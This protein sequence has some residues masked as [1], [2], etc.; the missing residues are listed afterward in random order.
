[1]IKINLL[2]HK[3]VKP[4]EKGEMLLQFGVIALTVAVVLGL[5]GWYYLLS[6]K[7][8]DLTRID[9]EKTAQ[10]EKLKKKTSEVENYKQTKLDSENK[11]KT[12]EEIDKGRVRMTQVLNDINRVMSK[13]LWL[14]SL[15]VA[16]GTFKLDGAGL[17]KAKITAFAD[18]LKN[19]ATF[20]GVSLGDLTDTPSGVSGVK[21]YAFSIK[22][23]ITG[24]IPLK[25]VI[26]EPPA[27][28]GAKPA[29][30]PAPKPQPPATKK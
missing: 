14:T 10:L 4:K 18:G 11:L 28:P 16:N 26:P 30:K 7:V 3:K 6:S 29:A 17:D 2:P 19:S 15:A 21:T 23:S 25:V 5:G 13:D 12:I 24:F 27:K 20:T 22:G 9:Q 1:M 8:S